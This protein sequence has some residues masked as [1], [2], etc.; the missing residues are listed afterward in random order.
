VTLRSVFQLQESDILHYDT[1][2]G[3]DESRSAATQA[4]RHIPWGRKVLFIGINANSTLG[5]LEA[6]EVLGRQSCTAVVS[7]NVSKRI[8]RELRRGNPMLIGGVDYF[9]HIYGGK[10]LQ[11]ALSMLN[12]QQVP[13]AAYTE[14]LLVNAE[15][16][17][18]IYPDEQAEPM[19]D[20]DRALPQHGVLQLKLPPQ[21]KLLAAIQPQPGKG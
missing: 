20:A 8:R 6:A 4:L 12:G 13:P 2:G 17:D 15:N 9:P 7:Q 5:A 11:M 3:L 21:D 18:H 1:R 16:V 14:H 19:A 10:V